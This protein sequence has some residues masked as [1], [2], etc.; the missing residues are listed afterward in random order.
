[1]LHPN[2]LKDPENIETMFSLAKEAETRGEQREVPEQTD[3]IQAKTIKSK[4]QSV[5]RFMEFIRDRY[6]FI[7][8]NRQDMTDL[9]Q[10]FSRLQKNL[11]DLIS[12][13]E[14]LI[15]EF[16][17]NIFINAED[18]QKYS[19]SEFVKNN[20]DLLNKLDQEGKQARACLQ[21]PIN[22]RDHLM[23]VLT[24]INA[25]CVSNLIC[26]ILKEVQAAK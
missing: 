18:F 25:L 24:F 17:S 7:G 2:Q 10:F 6:I 20:I 21:D 26:I 5:I 3:H 11:K 15:K 13:Q 23:L 1:M 14:N 4:L 22:K 12:E 16:R 8:L 9:T 19:S